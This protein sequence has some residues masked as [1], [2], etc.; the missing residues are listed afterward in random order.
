MPDW[1]S[2]LKKTGL[3]GG[4]LLAT[5]AGGLAIAG[6]LP[7]PQTV[8]PDTVLSYY[9]GAKYGGYGGIGGGLIGSL[10]ASRLGLGAKGTILGG[11]LGAG[12][13][14]ILGASTV[15][16]EMQAGAMIAN[17]RGMTEQTMSAGTYS[18]LEQMSALRADIARLHRPIR[19]M[20]Y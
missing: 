2:L 20:G 1:G 4:G 15:M 8:N 17:T 6:S 11:L 14:S 5:A 18:A 3:V 13:G 12:V 19:G 9:M 10:T 7:P 16:S